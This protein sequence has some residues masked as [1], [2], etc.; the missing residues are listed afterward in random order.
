MI[1]SNLEGHLIAIPKWISWEMA[2]LYTTGLEARCLIYD[3]IQWT[4]F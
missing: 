2:S 3:T 4:K 1:V